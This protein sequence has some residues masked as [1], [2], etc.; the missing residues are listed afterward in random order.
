MKQI[1]QKDYFYRR[2]FTCSSPKGLPFIVSLTALHWEVMIENSVVVESRTG[3]VVKPGIRI[4]SVD[5]IPF[6]GSLPEVQHCFSAQ[7]ITDVV[8]DKSVALQHSI[9][10]VPQG[11]CT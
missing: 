4:F 9:R 11:K 10:I 7:R 1:H 2:P 6:G 5:F 8:L 3:L